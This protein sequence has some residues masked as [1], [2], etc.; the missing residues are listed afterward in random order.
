MILKIKRKKAT[1]SMKTMMRDHLSI[2]SSP[3]WMRTA[4]DTTVK[5]RGF[6]QI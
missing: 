5:K 6:K 2:S 4:R 1:A 3:A